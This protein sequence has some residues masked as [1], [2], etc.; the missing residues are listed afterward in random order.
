MQSK[1]ILFCY[2]YLGGIVAAK[3]APMDPVHA[4]VLRVLTMLALLA[5]LVT[6]LVRRWRRIPTSSVRWGTTLL[7]LAIPAILLGYTRYIDTNTVP[8]TRVGAIQVDSG[9]AVLTRD[10][11]IPDTCRVRLHKSTAT[12]G[13][14]QIRLHGRLDA[15]V[16]ITSDDGIPALDHEGR[17][18]FKVV[19]FEQESEVITVREEDP[20]GTDYVV[21]QPFSDIGRIEVLSK[22][23]AGA[24]DVYRISNHISSFVRP[25]RNQAPVT[26]LGRVSADPLVYG[27]KTVLPITPYFIQYRTDGPFYKVTG[28][29][30]RTTMQPRMTGYD[31][32]ARS[33]AFGY[34]VVV[35]GELGGARPQANPGGFDQQRFLRNHNIYGHIRL[36]E[37]REGPLPIVPVAPQGEELR[38]GN[39]LVEFSLSVRDRM[40]LVI[41][42]TLPYPQSAF[43]GA[44]T[45]GLRYGLQSAR[46][47]LGMKMPAPSE[48]V[49]DGR[50]PAVT[51][52]ELSEDYIFDE[53][54]H[55][56]VNH[57]LAVSGLHVTIITALFMGIFALLRMPRKVYVPAI[58]LC[59]VIFAIITGARPSTLRAVIMNSLFLLTWAYLGQGLQASVLFGVPVAAFLILLHNPLMI[60]DPSFTLSFGAILS[61][62]LLTGP[63]HERF[64]NLRGNNFL[65]FVLVIAL[66][67]WIGAAH[68][69]LLV[70]PAFWMPYTLLWVGLAWGVR[71]LN[72]R[73]VQLVGGLSYSH[74][75]AA[76]GYFFAAQFAIQIGMMLPLS[77]FYFS[78]W[79]F[80]GAYANLV[81][82]PLIGIVLQLG[83]VAG[84]AGFIP[85]LGSYIALILNASNWIFS[86]IF[87]WIAHVSSE[88]FPYPFMTRPTVGFLLAYYF[89][90]AAFIWQQPLWVWIKARCAGWGFKRASA[91]AFFAAAIAAVLLVPALVPA[92]E[93]EPEGLRVT[94]L[95][96][97]YGSSIFV[98]TPG[99]KT[100]LLD[101]GFVEHE[102]SRRNEA[103]RTILPYLSTRRIRRLDTVVLTS[104]LPER[105]AGMGHILTHCGVHTLYVPEALRNITPDMAYEEFAEQLAGEQY[106]AYESEF[107][108]RI[109]HDVIR[110]PAWPKRVSMAKAL[111][112]RGDTFF[113]RWAG[114]VTEVKSLRK[115]EVLLEEEHDGQ[116]FRI[117]V[118]HPGDEEM[119]ERTIENRSAVLRMTYGNFSML[120]TSDL[121]YAG[122]RYLT[123]SIPADQLRSDVMIIPHHGTA[124]PPGYRGDI[125]RAT[126][127]ALDESLGPLLTKVA[128]DTV[129]FEFGNPRPVVGFLNRDVLHVYENTYRFVT[130]RVGPDAVLKTDSDL[131]IFIHSDGLGYRVSTQAEKVIASGSEE[132]VSDIEVGF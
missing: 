18:R 52:D 31:T 5:L 74:I 16:A 28:G 36:F 78:R 83:M 44:V 3:L 90:C 113:N 130:D 38:R 103:V 61:L 23:G 119:A 126:Q 58:I 109:Y 29:T 14:I 110:T 51:L 53:F 105:V 95:S 67:T 89:F 40:L 131:A 48:E 15:R 9:A 107:L 64:S 121:D 30:V 68:W 12:T 129:L 11:P 41:K 104:P 80:A 8:D 116:T 82:I 69:H 35:Q 75:P 112:R 56:G 45:L 37:P 73:N 65:F 98:E 25:G 43:L 125:K 46:Y 72:R 118:L 100:V 59:L 27:F 63:F 117:E 91:P 55:A 88:L 99:G 13:T 2:L 127:R 4:P 49:A 57:V 42:Q 39:G 19:K 24:V 96:V 54:R 81:A 79:P 101:A 93:K 34:D 70:R 20:V 132:S 108:E 76:A 62:A 120:L 26:V 22:A 47:T 6:A 85:G 92:G 124:L 111:T 21:A 115:G 122:Q 97:G 87:L 86:S 123:E 7:A 94:V 84:L 17:W 114:W 71:S 77:A 1:V 106:F 128:P 32:F 102:R 10:A 66:T 33:D 50:A 60:V